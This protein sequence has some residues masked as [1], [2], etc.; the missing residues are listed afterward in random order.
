LF[1]WTDIGRVLLAENERSINARYPDT[2]NNP[3]NMPGKIGEDL[4]GYKFRYFEPFIHMAHTQKC[5]WVIKN[6]H[7]FDYQ[8]CETDDYDRSIAKRIIGTIEA[9][10]INALPGYDKAPWGIDR[11][12]VQA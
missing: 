6:C 5:V 9:E 2:I 12:R 3:E 1:E 10:A 4:L 11:E 8:A 7:C